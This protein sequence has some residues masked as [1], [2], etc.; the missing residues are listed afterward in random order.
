MLVIKIEGR[1]PANITRIIGKAC[2]LSGFY[3]QSFSLPGRGYV[4]FDRK[5][6]ASRQEEF[7][8][9]LVI[10]DSGSLQESLRHAKEKSVVIV[11]AP[12][13]ARPAAAKRRKL[14]LLALDAAGMSMNAARSQDPSMPLLGALVKQCN[15]ITSRAARA[16]VGESRELLAA[17]EEGYRGVK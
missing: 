9:F 4:K 11:N 12:E 10:M 8:D 7:S 3:V 16:A 13:K 5:P 2:F 14:R 15:R 6:F 17:M 1:D